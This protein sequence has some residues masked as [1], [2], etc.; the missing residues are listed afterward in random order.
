MSQ[1]CEIEQSVQKRL[2]QLGDKVKY[3]Q[4]VSPY[5]IIFTSD[6]SEDPRA[7]LSL[8]PY[9]YILVLNTNTPT[10]RETT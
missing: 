4:K 9:S 8:S 5:T 10:L 7:Y 6:K 1:G 2:D 3:V